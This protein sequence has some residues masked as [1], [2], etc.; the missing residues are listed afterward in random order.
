VLGNSTR[1]A[2]DLVDAEPAERIAKAQAPPGSCPACR[3]R[4]KGI[5]VISSPCRG[6]GIA[7]SGFVDVGSAMDRTMGTART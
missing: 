4:V 3:G 6:L 7:A 5:F 2:C 1:C